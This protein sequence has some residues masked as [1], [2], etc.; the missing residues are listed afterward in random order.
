MANKVCPS[1]RVRDPRGFVTLKKKKRVLIHGEVASQRMHYP[2]D[3]LA[4]AGGGWGAPSGG[5]FVGWVCAGM[6]RKSGHA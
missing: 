1:L 4:L 5:I 6:R 2:L 3:L